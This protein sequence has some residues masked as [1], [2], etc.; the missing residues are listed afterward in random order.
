ML[1][2]EVALDGRGLEP[3]TTDVAVGSEVLPVS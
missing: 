1:P 3:L 2:F